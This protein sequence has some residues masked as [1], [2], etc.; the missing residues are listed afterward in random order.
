MIPLDKRLKTCAQ[1]TENYLEA[2]FTTAHKSRVHEAMRYA[3]L[4]GGK[5]MRPF[6]VLETARLFGSKSPLLMQAACA[7]ELVHCYSL[8]H[9]DLPA[10]DNDDLRRGKPTLHKAFDE[11]TAILAG[12]ALLT[13]AFE[14]LSTPV[15][16]APLQLKLIKELSIAAGA[17]GMVQGQ[18]LDLASEGRFETSKP[19]NEQDI[20]HLQNLKTGA[21]IV[22]AVRMGAI[23]G[24]ADSKQ[25]EALSAYAQK[26]GLAFQIADDLIDVEG[27]AEIAGK[28]TAK[29][30]EKGKATF[31]LLLGVQKAR[32][33][34]QMT[35]DAAINDLHDFGNKAAHLCA[36]IQLM[37]TRKH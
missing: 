35:I 5:R 9:D 18:M 10:M 28:A 25:F 33:K 24:G 30:Q 4:G 34:L 6:L 21:L 22:C 23:I 29:D 32:E 8:I 15:H 31:V 17:Q 19:L 7:I 14:I 20:T 3:V 27:D 12:D 1:D 37:A 36:F 11:A 16:D 2:V 13:L 26:C